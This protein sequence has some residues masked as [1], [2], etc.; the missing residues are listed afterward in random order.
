M[1]SSVQRP[2]VMDQPIV[3]FAAYFHGVKPD[4]LLEVIHRIVSDSPD[5]QASISA[6]AAI[7]DKTKRVVY[8]VVEVSCGET[9]SYE[10][11]DLFNRL[12]DSLQK[13]RLTSFT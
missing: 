8:F 10:T 12:Q 3:K 7:D 6:V 1:R 9:I 5:V 2:L 4:N 13:E 11:K